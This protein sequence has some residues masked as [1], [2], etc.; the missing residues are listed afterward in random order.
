MG[1]SGEV[2]RRAQGLGCRIL[3]ANRSTV[4]EPAAAERI[5]SFAELDLMLPQC[6]TLV[7]ACALAAET[8]GLID[9]HRFAVM[10]PG[11]LLINIAGAPIMDEDALYAPLQNGR[12]WEAPRSICGGVI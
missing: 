7:I 12:H 10:K 5:F 8:E 9:A 4:A 1:G 3:A 6:D 11:A 2:A